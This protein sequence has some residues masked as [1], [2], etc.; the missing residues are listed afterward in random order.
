MSARVLNPAM[1]TEMSRNLGGGRTVPSRAALARVRRDLF[2]P[3]D[4]AAAR[5]LA[6]RELRAQSLL[7]NE[8]WGFDFH[9][10]IPKSNSRYEWE[11]VTANDVVPEPYALR[12]M[13]Y[14]RKHAPSTP[15]KKRDENVQQQQ[16]QSLI[17]TSTTTTTSTPPQRTLNGTTNVK[18]A[19]AAATAVVVVA[20]SSTTSTSTTTATAT[21]IAFPT[22]TSSPPPPPIV[23]NGKSKKTIT[24]PQRTED[25]L[26]SVVVPTDELLDENTESERTPPQRERSRVPE[27]GEITPNETSSFDNSFESARK[28]KY[29][30]EST[31]TNTTPVLPTNTRKQ[32]T[33]THFMKSRKRSL[34]GSTKS[35]IEP[36]EKVARNAGQIRS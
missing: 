32:S 15:R 16:Q 31:N 6:E 35:V 8:R 36:P 23:A 28:K 12:G 27:I 30:I 17:I 7:D 9:L 34:N 4:H 1:M 26:V 25:K 33:I 20:A 22:T 11:I 14:L 29:S 10:E 2:G 24:T 19:T 5:A 18:K 3:V 13:P 21:T